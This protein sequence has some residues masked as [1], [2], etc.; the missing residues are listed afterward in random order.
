MT[1]HLRPHR[2]FF[3][4][5]DIDT[6]SAD[7]N[8]TPIINRRDNQTC[9]T[10]AYSTVTKCLATDVTATTD[11]TVTE[12]ATRAPAG[13]RGSS[14][15]GV[16]CD[17]VRRGNSTKALD[18]RAWLPAPAPAPQRT[19]Q[20]RAYHVATP[21]NYD[22]DKKRFFRGEMAIAYANG[23]TVRL[24]GYE[25]SST[26]VIWGSY[27]DMLAIEGLYGCTAVIVIS[28]RGVLAIHI[29]EDPTFIS[30]SDERQENDVQPEEYFQTY[31]TDPLSYPNPLWAYNQAGICNLRTD[32]G[33]YQEIPELYDYR[34]MFNNDA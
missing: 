18:K 1:I 5:D 16:A 12:T 33:I 31:A 23:R 6:S 25:T 11:V 24:Q 19:S 13:C 9:L 3:G 2:T 29:W 20:P 32:S 34:D 4:G 27:V 30:W 22:G 8:T 10:V 15:G 26:V 28:R 7:S 17:L 14:C 21:Q